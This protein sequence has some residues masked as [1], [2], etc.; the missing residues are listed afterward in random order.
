MCYIYNSIIIYETKVT[1]DSSAQKKTSLDRGP[2]RANR[3]PGDPHC[4]RGEPRAGP[5]LKGGVWEWLGHL[6][7]EQPVGDVVGGQEG[8]HQV[9]DGAGFP[10][11]RTE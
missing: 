6:L 11:V 1:T 3:S 7:E 2:Q 8:R 9:C 5:S 10:T 4:P